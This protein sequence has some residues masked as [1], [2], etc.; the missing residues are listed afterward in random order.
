MNDMEDESDGATT[1]RGRCVC[2]YVV[3]TCVYVRVLYVY[4]RWLKVT[5]AWV[6]IV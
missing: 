6:W 1:E 2:Q 5:Y 3:C 4:E